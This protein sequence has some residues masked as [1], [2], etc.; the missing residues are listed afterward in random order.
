MEEVSSNESKPQDIG[1]DPD[2]SGCYQAAPESFWPGDGSAA[3]SL[4][5]P[6]RQLV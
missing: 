3:G 4:I 5:V 1:L 6:D 2:R